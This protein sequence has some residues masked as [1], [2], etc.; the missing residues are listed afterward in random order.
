MRRGIKKIM[1]KVRN[2]LTSSPTVWLL[3]SM[4]W[5]KSL[6]TVKENAIGMISALSK[7]SSTTVFIGITHY[8]FRPSIWYFSSIAQTSAFEIFVF[9]KHHK[10]YSHNVDSMVKQDSF[11]LRSLL[12]LMHNNFVAFTTQQKRFK[13]FFQKWRW[14]DILGKVLYTSASRSNSF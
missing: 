8:I 9:F 7:S 14:K 12:L 3:S 10:T 13:T 4:Y 2:F 6:N 1:N 5:A 11:D